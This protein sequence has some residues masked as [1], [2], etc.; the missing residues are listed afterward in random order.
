MTSWPSSV[1]L[2]ALPHHDEDRTAPLPLQSSHLLARPQPGQAAHGGIQSGLRILALQPQRRQRHPGSAQS[3]AATG[4]ISQHL[5]CSVKRGLVFDGFVCGDAAL[6][7]RGEQSDWKSWHT[8]RYKQNE[9]HLCNTRTGSKAGWCLARSE[10]APQADGMCRPCHR[11]PG[12]MSHVPGQARV[13][14]S[15]ICD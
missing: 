14:L 12:F 3:L 1:W 11:V 13:A 7:K 6:S 2:L 4:A 10:H 9:P 15:S 5:R 8:Q